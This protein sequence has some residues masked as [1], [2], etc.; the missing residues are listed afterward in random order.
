TGHAALTSPDGFAT[1][2]L[3]AGAWYLYDTGKGF[4][5]EEDIST[6]GPPGPGSITNR[7][8]SGTTLLQSGAPFQLSAVSGNVIGG[9]GASSTPL[10]PNA[11]LGMN[12]V[13][14][15]AVGDLTSI[16]TQG[17]DIPDAAYSGRIAFV[18]STNLAN[19]HGLITLAAPLLGDF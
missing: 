15:T 12:F 6:S 1:N 3:N 10:V 16:T 14:P 13:P 2:F 4:F 17:G 11:A 9:F 7:A 5:V 18:D 8:L 19:G